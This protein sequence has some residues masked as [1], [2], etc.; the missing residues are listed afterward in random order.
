MTVSRRRDSTTTCEVAFVL[1]K[2][3]VFI[4]YNRALIVSLVFKL[5]NEGENGESEQSCR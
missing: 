4:H 5:I 3:Q 1:A 2:K